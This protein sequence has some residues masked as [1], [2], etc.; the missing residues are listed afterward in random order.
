MTRFRKVVIGTMMWNY[1]ASEL[2]IMNTVEL[3]RTGIDY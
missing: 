1:S 3:F 2:I